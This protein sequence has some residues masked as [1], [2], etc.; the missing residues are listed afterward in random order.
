MLAD[1]EALEPLV[2]AFFA[3][4]VETAGEAERALPLLRLEPADASATQRRLGHRAGAAYLRDFTGRVAPIQIEPPGWML[5]RLNTAP[6][7]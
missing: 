1:A 3:L 6:G 7:S 4:G 2:G 5:E